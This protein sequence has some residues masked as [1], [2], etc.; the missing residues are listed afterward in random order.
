MTSL[1]TTSAILV[2]LLA[3][4]PAAPSW[5]Q[6]GG[7]VTLAAVGDV[8][9]GGSAAG[10]LAQRGFDHSFAATREHLQA[11]DL[12]VGNLEAPL[13]V[14]EEEWLDKTFRFKVPPASSAALRRA[15]F[16]VLTLANNHLG[17]F[18]PSGV[19]ETL[20]T[21]DREGI[22]RAGAGANLAEARRPAVLE[23]RGEKIAF[24]AYSN[25]FPTEFYAGPG[26]PGTAPGY[27]RYVR[28]D[29]RA[30]RRIADYVVVS[31]HWGGERETVPKDYQRELAHLAID[32]G[33][34]VVLG[35]HPHVLQ[36]VEAY[37]GGIIFYSLGNFAFGSFSR[38][39]HTSALARIILRDG[40]VA[41]AEVLPL[42]VLNARVLFCPCPLEGAAAEE[43]V[44]DLA[45]LTR[46]FGLTLERQEG[47]F[48]RLR[49]F[50]VAERE[51]TAGAP[52]PEP[53]KPAEAAV[54]PAE[55]AL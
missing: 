7:P 20:A 3:L 51:E 34:Q 22:A 30:A 12:A 10:V 45:L 53:A 1:R 37:R 29:V 14:S 52:A 5:A 4:L 49:P 15:G 54:T 24:L 40:K 28:T 8:L 46:P 38:T 23:V 31:F 41:A 48:W 43:A 36:G 2:F 25:T 33:A 44:D 32:S 35:H 47:L 19:L 39:A 16:D 9:L 18:G 6:A 11:A 27:A 26:R 55:K 13:T 17:D 21:L 42:D 50:S